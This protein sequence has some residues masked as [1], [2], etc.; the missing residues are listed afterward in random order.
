M[1]S[2]TNQLPGYMAQYVGD[3]MGKQEAPQSRDHHNVPPRNNKTPL[4]IS[5]KY[6]SFLLSSISP[7]VLWNQR[8][9]IF[10]LERCT[11]LCTFGELAA[12]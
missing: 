9:A 10:P 12:C 4:L 6:C 11:G 1:D 2:P 7:M 8:G 5:N 3:G